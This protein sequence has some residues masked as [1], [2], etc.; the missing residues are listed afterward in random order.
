MKI[1]VPIE[2]N[3]MIAQHFGHCEKY[4]IYSI[5]Q[6][7]T[8]DDK[9]ALLTGGDHVCHSNIGNLLADLG[10]EIMLAGGIGG[11]AVNKLAASNI[12]TIRGCEGNATQVVE[13]YLAGKLIDSGSS[14]Q[15]HEQHHASD[16]HHHE[17]HHDHNH[18]C[19]HN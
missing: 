7:R 12:E 13:L 4:M 5:T 9:E 8:I 18:S 17:H 11:G 14:C 16:E 3:E 19:H 15:T 2:E 1:A 10:V 6:E